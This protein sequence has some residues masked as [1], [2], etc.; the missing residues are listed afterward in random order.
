MGADRPRGGRARL[1]RPRQLQRRDGQDPRAASSASTPACTCCTRP[2]ARPRAAAGR[3]S[4]PMAARRSWRR[5]CPAPVVVEEASRY[6][7]DHDR[8][9]SAGKVREFWGNVPQVVKAYAWARGMGGDGIARGRRP[10]GARQQLHGAE[11]AEI[12]GVTRSHPDRRAPAHG[13]DPLRPRPAQGGDRRRHGRRREPHG[14]LRRR[15]LLDEPR[16]LGRARAVH[17]RGR[18]DVVK[19]DLDYWIAVVGASARRR[20]ATRSSSRRRRTTRRSPRSTA[21][22]DD[23][24]R[25][26]MTWRAYRRK[27][28]E[29]DAQARAA[30]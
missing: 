25:W 22:L 16:A 26:A 19:E 20:D 6:R 18:R 27:L 21:R 7:L 17:A 13:D 23:P 24:S 5:S 2:S 8:P 11:A 10:V 29:R 12:R 9:Q 14:R 28:A 4:A 1:L 3:R 30:E 15:P